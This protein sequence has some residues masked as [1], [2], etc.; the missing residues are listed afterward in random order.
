LDGFGRRLFAV[1][2]AE[3]LRFDG[4]FL[5]FYLHVRS[6]ILADQFEAILP[7]AA[8]W[9]QKQ[10]QLILREGAPLSPKEIADARAVGVREPERVR[11]LLVDEIPAPPDALLKAA[12]AEFFPEAPSGLTLDHGIFIRRDCRTD[13]HLV[14]HELVHTSQYERLGGIAPFLR[15]YLTEC[16][17]FGYRNAPLEREA[18]EIAAQIC[19]K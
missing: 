14:V 16:A 1:V 2:C 5:A 19:A 10:E 6:E 17:S 4:W 15:D 11:V 18:E 12:T 13:R 7:L 3:N 8:E 9:A